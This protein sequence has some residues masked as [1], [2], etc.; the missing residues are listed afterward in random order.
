M[1]PDGRR[2]WRHSTRKRRLEN[3]RETPAGVFV[4]VVRLKSDGDKKE[5]TW[6]NEVPNPGSGFVF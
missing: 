2:R 1:P 3:A 6:T 5:T 4:F